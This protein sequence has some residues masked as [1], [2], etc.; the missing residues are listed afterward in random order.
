MGL[1]LLCRLKL[2]NLS[3]YVADGDFSPVIDRLKSQPGLNASGDVILRNVTRA[4][5]I[6]AKS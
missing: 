1:D 5:A 3:I 4:Y 6:S 2:N